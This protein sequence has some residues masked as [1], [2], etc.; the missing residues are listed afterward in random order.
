M[1]RTENVSPI[2][3][4]ITM[5]VPNTDQPVSLPQARPLRHGVV[6]RLPS[7]PPAG[8]S[9]DM[10]E[11]A[12]EIA[13]LGLV[14]PAVKVVAGDNHH[15]VFFPIPLKQFFAEGEEGVMGQAVIL[16]NDALGFVFKEPVDRRAHRDPTAQILITKQRLELTRPVYCRG[17]FPDLPAALFLSRSILAG[18]IRGNI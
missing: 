12:E 16:Q 14:R 3:P 2:C 11:A 1:G 13:V 9:P 7:A 10:R 4:E 5:A 6:V 8:P 17:N 15:A 18:A